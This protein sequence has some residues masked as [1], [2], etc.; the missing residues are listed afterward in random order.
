VLRTAVLI[1]THSAD[2]H[3]PLVRAELERLG[4]EVV[5][6]DTDAFPQTT[7]LTFSVE[8]GV[9]IVRLH[10]GKSQYSGK[11]FA[12]VLY[13]HVRLPIAPQIVEPDPRRLA[14][15]ELRWT[16][17]GAL[18]ALEPALWMNHPQANRL[19]RSKLLQLRLATS[20]GFKVPETQVTAD[21]Q[22][23]RDQWRAW[24]GR[25]IAKLVGGQIVGRDVESQ[26]FIPTSL[27]SE[28]DVQDDAAVGACPAIYQRLIEKRYDL[29]VTVVGDELFACRLHSKACEG[30]QV[31]WRAAGSITLEPCEIDNATAERCRMLMRALGLE[32]A[33]MD[34]IVTP[35]DEIVFLEI[36]AAG[37]WAWVEEATG[38][39]IAAAIAT[40][41]AATTRTGRFAAAEAS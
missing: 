33:G 10:I 17:E 22:Q 32:I 23:I 31:D 38:L 7:N 25:M 35:D 18:L 37:Q 9:P 27:V 34:F 19:A 15:S 41:L 28:N 29:R 21:P 36:N 5:C 6:F 8:A 24:G 12:A 2:D 26:F 16:L 11:N 1:V 20:I 13:R 40:R 4:T 30:A 3:V 14:E 39:P